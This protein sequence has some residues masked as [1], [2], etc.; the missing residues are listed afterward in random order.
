MRLSALLEK[1]KI[2]YNGAEKT[3]KCIVCDS[4]EATEDSLFVCIKGFASD[5]HNFVERAYIR[6]C[7]VFV[8]ER[9]IPE[10]EDI[11]VIKVEN[12]RRALAN[13]SAAFYDFPA[14]KLKVIGITGTKG[15][16]TTA[17]MLSS[18]LSQNGISCGYIGSNGIEFAGNR[19][20]TLNTTPESLDLHYYFD[21]MVKAGVK[22]VALEVSSQAL[23]LDRTYGIPFF[24]TAFTNLAPDHIGGAEHPTFEHY[25][26]CKKKLFSDYTSEFSVFSATDEASDYMS[27]D[28]SAM[29]C[30]FG[31]EKGDFSA[32]EITPFFDGGALGIE[33]ECRALTKKCTVSLPMPGKFSVE[34]ALCAVAIAH[35]FGVS[36]DAAA[37]AL[38]HTYVFGRFELV[39]TELDAVFVID[40]AHNGF[41]ITSALNTL[42]AYNPNRLW[43]VS[44]SVGGRTFGRRAEIGEAMSKLCDIA[45]L[46]A[47]NPDLEDP[48]KICDDIHKAFVR[49]IPC[50]SFADR[51]DAIKYVVANVKKGDIV[52]F[53]GKGHEQY[54]F[55]RGAKIP[56]SERRLIEKYAMEIAKEYV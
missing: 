45:V 22:A 8:V 39:K 21:Q 11:T 51:E 56:F 16:T 38:A 19:F 34:N 2:E 28:C 4:R 10:F 17:L 44:G 14:S 48:L 41:S 49:D 26:D 15:K 29:M 9:D 53:A 36:A 24:V 5:G 6:G 20:E 33:F 32:T 42:R 25:R 35:R 37:D 47:D 1:A 52:L 43:C 30:T 50:K 27:R 55:I 46:T 31:L 18:V 13:I 54:Q 3:V 12:S 40:Y 7:R 23:Y